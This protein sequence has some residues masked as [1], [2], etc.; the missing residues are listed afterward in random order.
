M[1]KIQTMLWAMFALLAVVSCD[2]ISEG[3]RYIYVDKKDNP[4]DSDTI[5]KVY[6]AVLLQDFTGQDCL[7]C[8]NATDEIE[9]LVEQYGDSVVV[10]VGIHS[11]QL[12]FKTYVDKKTGETII[13]LKTDIGQKYYDDW[14][15]KAQP[16]GVIDYL[17]QVDYQDWATVIYNELQKAPVMQLKLTPVYDEA[18]RKLD[19][20]VDAVNISTAALSGTLQLWVLEDSIVAEQKQ[21][22][23]RVQKDYV[24]NHVFRDAVNGTDGSGCAVEAGKDQRQH[25][26][27]TLPADYKAGN[28]SVVA[29][30]YDAAGV[31]QVVKKHIR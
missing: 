1:K 26:T 25:F 30:F 8:P 2:N 15:I 4:Q 22:N 6:R 7:N 21:P 14:Q 16:K 11:G 17:G 5:V 10:P 23:G 13:G 19:I 24:H 12:S 3:D 29:F 18:S 28:V 9:K 27:Y 31:Q 20:D